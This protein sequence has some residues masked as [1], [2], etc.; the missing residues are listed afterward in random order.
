MVNSDSLNRIN[1]FQI[2]NELIYS[3]KQHNNTGKNCVILYLF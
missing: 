1:Q 2:S 3:D